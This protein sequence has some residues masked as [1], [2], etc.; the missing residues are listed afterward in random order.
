MRARASCRKTKRLADAARTGHGGGDRRTHAQAVAKKR[1]A[2]SSHEV[3]TLP[4]SG[5]R[6][7]HPLAPPIELHIVAAHEDVAEDPVGAAAARPNPQRTHGAVAIDDEV[8][9][10]ERERFAP[11][12]EREAR[13]SGAALHHPEA[14]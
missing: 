2:S 12:H 5:R 13:K 10:V 8:L 9:E 14:L 4:A 6:E 11:E 7:A 1:L 3:A